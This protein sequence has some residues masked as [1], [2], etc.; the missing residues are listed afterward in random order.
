[1][2]TGQLGR[3]D[4]RDVKKLNRPKARK[5]VKFLFLTVLGQPGQKYAPDANRLIF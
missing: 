4:A 5:I 3:Q 2:S 1:R